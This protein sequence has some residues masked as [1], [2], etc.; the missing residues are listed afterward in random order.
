MI[1]TTLGRVNGIQ[2]L[3]LTFSNLQ[4]FQEYYDSYMSVLQYSGTPYDSTNIN[5][6]RCYY[7]QICT[8]NGDTLCSDVVGQQLKL[9]IHP[10]TQ[11]TTGQTLTSYS[12]NITLPTISRDINFPSCQSGCVGQLDWIVNEINSC[13]STTFSYTSNVGARYERPFFSTQYIYYTTTG[14]NSLFK[15]S[16]LNVVTYSYRT[17]VYTGTGDYTTYTF[18]PQLSANTSWYYQFE[19][20]NFNNLKTTLYTNAYIFRPEV[21]DLRNFTISGYTISNFTLGSLVKVYEYSGGTVVYS[22]P[23]FII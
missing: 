19:G 3:Q 15:T 4:D 14:G 17:F 7:L 16:F 23:N 9:K 21:T 1:T 13:S 8:A 11:V 5:Y 22:N 10:S 2:T 6:Y 12:M 18:I 20:S